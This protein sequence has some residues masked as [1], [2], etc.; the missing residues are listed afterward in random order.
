MTLLPFFSMTP[1]NAQALNG[2]AN[3]SGTDNTT[4][5]PNNSTPIWVI[6]AGLV[7]VAS[8]LLFA[9][10]LYCLMAK[11]K[12]K[13]ARKE[14][15][16]AQEGQCSKGSL[17]QGRQMT[18]IVIFSLSYLPIGSNTPTNKSISSV[19]TKTI[20]GTP[21]RSHRKECSDS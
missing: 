3:N 10:V 2:S 5:F 13:V 15:N 6:V 12:T 14:H 17:F 1:Q 7:L 11:Q 4:S 18:L 8:I 20:S 9:L 21:S 19:K 16:S